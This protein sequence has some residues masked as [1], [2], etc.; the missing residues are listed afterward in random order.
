[1][2]ISPVNYI[3]MLED[4]SYSSLLKERDVL[5]REIRRFEKDRDRYE[6]ESMKTPSPDVR[7]Q[8]N[9]HYLEKL[10]ELISGAYNREYL[11]GDKEKKELI[12]SNLFDHMEEV[13]TTA[14]GIQRIKKNLSLDVENV[15]DWCKEKIQQS[16]AVISK[17]G[18]NW[19]VDV[20]GCIITVNTTSYTIITAKRMKQ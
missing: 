4:K 3:E 2:M 19:Y 12:R 7:Y 16:N 9:L 15:V 6:E 11:W 13:H 20:D 8:M 10:C 5:I 1:M 17:K 18:K 14:M